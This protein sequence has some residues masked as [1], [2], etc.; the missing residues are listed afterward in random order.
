MRTI[1]RSI[2]TTVLNTL[3]FTATALQAHR[4]FD[5]M[6]FFDFR[7]AKLAMARWDL[8]DACSDARKT[9]GGT[10]CC[11]NM[12]KLPSFRDLA[13]LEE[14]ECHQ[15][16]IEQTMSPMHADR[17]RLGCAACRFHRPRSRQPNGERTAMD[18]QGP[19]S[20]PTQRF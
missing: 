5:V 12:K 17:H 16:H 15:R 1:H 14:A 6:T 9:L 11:S 19:A 2:P 20:H 10:S 7:F 8:V 3:S 4:E 18:R 13:H